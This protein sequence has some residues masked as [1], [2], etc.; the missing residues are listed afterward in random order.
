MKASA[1]QQHRD[2]LLKEME[3]V[4]STNQMLCSTVK[5]QEETIKELEKK[6][7]SLKT[8]RTPLGDRSRIRSLNPVEK[9]A[10]G[11]GAKKKRVQAAR[12]GFL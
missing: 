9:L 10:P 8:K 11:G 2:L 7:V 5:S 4:T 12:Y 6:I 1:I 3:R